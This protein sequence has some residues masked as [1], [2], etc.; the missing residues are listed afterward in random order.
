MKF[1]VLEV[2]GLIPHTVPQEVT[3]HRGFTLTLF[4]WLVLTGTSCYNYTA[5]VFLASGSVH[6]SWSQVNFSVLWSS[7]K[8]TFPNQTL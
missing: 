3:I 2:F 4:N 6:T 8:L 5:N 7:E 1:S